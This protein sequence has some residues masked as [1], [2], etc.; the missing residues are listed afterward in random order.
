MPSQ[1]RARAF[2][3]LL[4]HILENKDFLSDFDTSPSD[5]RMLDPPI[6]LDREPAPDAPRENVDP[7]EELAFAREMKELREGVVKTVPAI[8]KKEEEAREK[9]RKETEREQAAVAGEFFNV[10]NS[11]LLPSTSTTWSCVTPLTLIYLPLSSRTLAGEPAQAAK[12]VAAVGG[13]P[14]KPSY[15]R[16]QHR[17]EMAGVVPGESISQ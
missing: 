10:Y 12:R 3:S 2:L 15:A 7:P 17:A 5:K 1:P 16:S 4:H 9:L 11:Q 14:K 6:R 13:R 8:Q